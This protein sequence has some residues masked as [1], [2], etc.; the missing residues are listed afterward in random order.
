VPCVSFAE[1]TSKRSAFK[2]QSL[3]VPGKRE[4][5]RVVRAWM[6][7]GRDVTNHEH[8][9]AAHTQNSDVMMAY[10]PTTHALESR[11]AGCRPSSG[12]SV[13]AEVGF[14]HSSQEQV[15]RVLRLGQTLEERV[16][17]FAEQNYDVCGRL[18]GQRDYA[19]HD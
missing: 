7:I 8:T 14:D 1:N 4:W 6:S 16:T 10:S 11:R 2:S 15:V 5:S 13:A 3:Q 17:L 12:A 18:I 9:R 19:Q